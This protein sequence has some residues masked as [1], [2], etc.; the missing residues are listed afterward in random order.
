[1]EHQHQAWALFGPEQPAFSGL[2]WGIRPA[3]RLVPP[4]AS[5]ADAVP[6]GAAADLP[7]A[8]AGP[9]GPP[10]PEASPAEP[11]AAIPGQLS[12]GWTQL[13]VW[14]LEPEPSQPSLLTPP[15][16]WEAPAP[17][18]RPARPS[19]PRSRGR[20]PAADQLTLFG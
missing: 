9:A 5:D 18:A 8:G 7:P 2:D 16:P 11:C 13:L 15:P 17:A 1:M 6:G 20:A 10:R 14:D 4:L 3:L 19:R 12:F